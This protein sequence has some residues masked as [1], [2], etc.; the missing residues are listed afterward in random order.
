MN[1]EELLAAARAQVAI[2]L[3]AYHE[4]L[5]V[6]LTELVELLPPLA[7]H[8]REPYRDKLRRFTVKVLALTASWSRP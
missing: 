7:R 5:I 1:R 6:L 3:L 8:G 4:T 2:M